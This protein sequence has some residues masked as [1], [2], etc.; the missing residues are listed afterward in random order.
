MQE[1]EADY[2]VVGSGAVGLAFVDTLLAESDATIVIVDRHDRPGGHWNDAYSFVQLHQPSAFYGVDSVPLG[3]GGKDAAG[4]NA[5]YCELA[6]GPEIS[7]YFE[8]VMQ[9]HLLASGR[10]KYYPAS[11]YIGD[12]MFRSLATGEM[13]KIKVNRKTV[14]ATFYGTT[15]PSTHTPK[16]QVADGVR[17]VAPN[18]LPDLWREPSG[19]PEK[20]AILGAGKTAMDVGVWLLNAGVNPDAITWIMPRDS[21]LLNRHHTQPG[22][23]FFQETFGGVADQ[24]QAIAESSSIDDVFERLE[25]CGVMIRIHPDKTPS[26][27]HCATISVGEVALLRQ[28]KTV[29]RKG[30][31]T[32]IEPGQI[33]L[34]HG[35]IETTPETLLIDCT[36]SA[37]ERKP[38]VA[39]F[40]DKLITLQM[41]RS[42]QPAFSA[43]IA[44]R[45]EVG[46]DND[47]RKN[48]LTGITPL[49]DGK[50]EFLTSTL[51]SM[52]NQLQWSQDEG[53]RHWMRTCRLDGF[54]ATIADV[55]RTDC[56]NRAIVEKIRKY[57]GLSVANIQT[58]LAQE[59]E[60]CP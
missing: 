37:V 31:I 17:L 13:T 20:I 8:T 46:F 26:M 40:Q 48:G 22:T 49:P 30:R 4:L 18:R 36:A 39:M 9:D 33:V 14:D 21:W 59:F 15:V 60:T 1:L 6:S 54:S 35:Q 11:D 32:A 10:V 29:V 47:V 3:S 50:R 41:V 19:R 42:C 5:G 57:A 23:E 7:A 28:I 24:M 44:A 25:A 56:D 45:I 12:G 51:T 2:L 53:L 58:L 27:Y 38:P 55:D 34:D 16:F 43:A 52:M